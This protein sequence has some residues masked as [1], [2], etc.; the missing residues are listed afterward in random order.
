VLA[1]RRVP[2]PAKAVERE[3]TAEKPDVIQRFFHSRDGLES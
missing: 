1:P 3:K 2:P